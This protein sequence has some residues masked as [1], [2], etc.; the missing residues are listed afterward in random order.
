MTR[1]HIHERE[2]HRI[3]LDSTLAAAGA[4]LITVVTLL[5]LFFVLFVSR[6]S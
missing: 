6:A 3:P 5:V 4:T 2:P 1:L